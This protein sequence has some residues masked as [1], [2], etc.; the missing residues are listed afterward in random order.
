MKRR[1]IYIAIFIISV[2]GLFVVQY[3]YLRIGLNLARVQ[4]DKKIASAGVGIKEE[5]ATENQLSFLVA[6]AIT[7]DN[8]F[9]LSK[10][11]VQ[12][13]S[14]YFLNDF[15]RQQLSENGI[16]TDFS[17]R[18]YTRDTLDYL[19]SPH[20][21]DEDSS[22]INYP[23]SLEGYL[24]TVIEK[25]LILEL[26]F[27]DLNSYFI[28]QLNGLTVPSLLFILAI[29]L[30]VVWILRSF[31]WQSNVITTTNEFIN[32]LTHE[33]K[34]P[35]FS[36]GLATKIL[37]ESVQEKQ[38][39]IVAMIRQQVEKLK[40]HID[41]VLELG[42]LESRKKLFELKEIN[43]RPL[44]KE[45][46]DYYREISEVEKTS[47]QCEIEERDF[48]V[49]AAANHLENAIANLIDNARKYSDV[50][51][52]K[53]KAV[54]EGKNLII[55][56]ADNGIGIDKK[57]KQHIFK[58]YYRISNGDVH[59]VKGYG[60]GL[61]YVKE[62]IKRHKGKIKIESETGKGTTVFIILP[63]RNAA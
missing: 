54:K 48:M 13:A 50:P 28:S 12:D 41:Q 22:L 18:L 36:V 8:Y 6:Q 45:W 25:P 59:K 23:F 31:Y 46:C 55:S 11:S 7:K 39:P 15:I 61:S 52:I 49:M 17:Y 47:F 30:V 27:N 62:I 40:R 32:N 37:E 58:K 1:N 10:D 4:F 20:P 53:L 14:R 56:V 42:N 5:L 60:L 35:V 38:K 9:K 33:L 26:Q 19:Q 44:L 2:L 29:I 51:E 3:Q 34:T 21:F 24:P 57:E 43:L 16:N 63:L